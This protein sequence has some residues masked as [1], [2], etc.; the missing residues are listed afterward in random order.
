M[1]GNGGKRVCGKTQE[2]CEEEI[3]A[4]F[5]WRKK[6]VKGADTMRGERGPEGWYSIK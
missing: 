3:F 4:D 2:D 1:G 6:D 5:F